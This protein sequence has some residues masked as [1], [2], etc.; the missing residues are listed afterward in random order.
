MNIKIIIG[1]LAIGGLFTL[2]TIFGNKG[3]TESVLIEQDETRVEED[4]VATALPAEMPTD[5][6]MYPDSVVKSVQNIEHEGV[7]N[8]TLSLTTSDSIA[9]VNTWYRGAL[10]ENGWAVTSDRN[11]GGYILIKGEKE[12]VATFMQAAN[13]SD[14]GFVV[15]TQRIQIR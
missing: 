3:D 15:I 2:V 13:N 12:N 11:V 7:R 10:N 14:I 4:T 8:I 6:P 9:D 5:V 1:I